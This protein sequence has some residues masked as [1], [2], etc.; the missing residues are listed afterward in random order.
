MRNR[1]R[2]LN[3]SLTLF[4]Q[5]GIAHVSTLQITT[6]LDISPGNLYYH[7]RNKEDIAKALVQEFD[8]AICRMRTEFSNQVTTLE[9][10][11]PFLLSLMALLAQYRFVLRDL[12][13]LVLGEP[14]LKRN[15][16]HLYNSLKT[17]NKRMFDHLDRL[18]ALNIEKEDQKFLADNSLMI[19]IGW[20][21]QL[22]MVSNEQEHAMILR[23]GVSRL[24]A[25]VQPHLN[26]T[27]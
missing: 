19:A 15:F 10:Y 27:T 23:Q 3:L 4:N 22:S 11:P 1:E 14:D 24:V 8:Q 21:N 18:D 26:T 25:L 7:F 2:V 9:D 13:T 12:E 17:L 6:E 20:V 5:Q 16:S